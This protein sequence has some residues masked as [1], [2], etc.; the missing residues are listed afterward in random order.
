[1]IRE[2]RGKSPKIALSAFVSEAA[3]VIGDIE[4]GE[5]SNVWPGA[6]IR[7]DF[8]TITIGQNT[9]LEDNC[10]VHSGTDLSIGNFVLVGHGAVIHC[11]RIGNNVLIGNN[12]T[13]LDG[14]E[15]GDFCIVGSGSLVRA[16]AKIPD[17]SLVVGNPALITGHL[18]PEQVAML[19]EGSEIYTR[20]AREYKQHGL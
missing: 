18:S 15:I 19:K 9:S 4:I 11:L 7:A 10:V 20:L 3:Y 2:F 6:V 5:H 14:A 16:E 12:A 17:R 8:G 13:V 1:M